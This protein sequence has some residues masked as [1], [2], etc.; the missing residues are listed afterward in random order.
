MEFPDPVDEA[1]GQDNHGHP[2]IPMGPQTATFHLLVQTP[3]H[4]DDYCHHEYRKE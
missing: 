2:E 3:A 1:N 4:L